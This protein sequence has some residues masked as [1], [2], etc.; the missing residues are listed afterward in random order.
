MA[1]LGGLIA[2]DGHLYRREVRI[3]FGDIWFLENVSKVISCLG[4]KHRVGK[5]VRVYLVRIYS[6]SLVRLLQE[7]YGL[8]TG[9]KAEI[10]VFPSWLD[11]DEKI[12]YI[13][14]FFD[15]DGSIGLVRSGIKRGIWGPYTSPRITFTSKSEAFL[16]DLRS[17]LESMGFRPRP[18]VRED[19]VYRLKLY[20]CLNLDLFLRIFYPFVINPRRM[21]GAQ[22]GANSCR[23][24]SG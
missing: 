16:E 23:E 22:A 7:N 6:V 24:M 12:A 5:G 17:F 15:G 14:G 8:K 3:A 11:Q 9:R 4:I 19:K 2:A 10:L 1:Y 21:L 20:G 13:V 18:V